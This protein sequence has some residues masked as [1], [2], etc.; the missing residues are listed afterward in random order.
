MNSKVHKKV[1]IVLFKM[2]SR[3]STDTM[4]Y[5]SMKESYQK[6]S[7]V[8]PTFFQLIHNL[9]ARGDEEVIVWGAG[10]L[11]PGGRS[12]FLK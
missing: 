8:E 5:E 10:L 12:G 2:V 11:L 6:T 4:G 3:S 1:E 9:E 7:V